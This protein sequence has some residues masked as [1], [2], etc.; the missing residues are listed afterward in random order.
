MSALWGNVAPAAPRALTAAPLAAVA[1]PD[2]EPAA[3]TESRPRDIQHRATD[4]SR[5]GSVRL[6]E[7]AWPAAVGIDQ[8]HPFIIVSVIDY[9]GLVILRHILASIQAADASG[10][11]TSGGAGGGSATAKVVAGDDV[12]TCRQPVNRAVGRSITGLNAGAFTQVSP[13]RYG[14]AHAV[15][16]FNNLAVGVTAIVVS[17]H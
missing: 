9:S 13:C 16:D 14:V 17:G 8:Q 2:L 6:P 1:N 4:G 11:A 5:G 12:A 15:A 3:R 7:A 10:A